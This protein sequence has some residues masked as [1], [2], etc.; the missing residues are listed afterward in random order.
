MVKKLA[1]VFLAMFM[2]ACEPYDKLVMEKQT[3]EVEDSTNV[4]FDIEIPNF[5]DSVIDINGIMTNEE[6]NRR[7]ERAFDSRAACWRKMD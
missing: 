4:T 3:D 6:A 5:F 7:L 2:M 1:L